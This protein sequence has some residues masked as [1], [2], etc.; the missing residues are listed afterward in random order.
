LRGE[1]ADQKNHLVPEILESPHHP[2]I[3][4]VTDMQE[5][6]R[7]VHTIL[8]SKL[9]ILPKQLPEFFQA[10]EILSGASKIRQ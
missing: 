9:S 5:W 2:K 3:H 1:I 6:R 8:D 7:N 10:E 4:G